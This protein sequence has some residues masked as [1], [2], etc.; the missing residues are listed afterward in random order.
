MYVNV[1]DNS[2][3]DFVNLQ[4]HSLSVLQQ[5]H[6][7]QNPITGPNVK[8]VNI[9]MRIAP[10]NLKKSTKVFLKPKAAKANTIA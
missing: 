6:G 9:G 4:S 1:N 8:G 10:G 3:G 5:P 7:E 2:I